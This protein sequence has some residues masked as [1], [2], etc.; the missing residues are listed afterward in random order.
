LA[1]FPDGEN[2]TPGGFVNLQN[3]EADY[4][5]QGLRSGALPAVGS[6][7]PDPTTRNINRHPDPTEDYFFHF[8][9]DCNAISGN[10]EWRN[11]GNNGTNQPGDQTWK[12]YYFNAS[13]NKVMVDQRG[14]NFIS[15]NNNTPLSEK[16]DPNISYIWEWD[17]VYRSHGVSVKLPFSEVTSQF[18]QCLDWNLT[19]SSSVNVN[20]GPKSS[21]VNV[22]SKKTPA[23][24]NAADTAKFY[25]NVHN[26]GPDD[27]TYDWYI[28]G[29]YNGNSFDITRCGNNTTNEPTITN[30][31]GVGAGQSCPTQVGRLEYW[32]NENTKAGGTTIDEGESYQFPS[33]ANPGDTYCERIV[34]TDA[35]GPKTASAPSAKACAVY[36]QIALSVD[37]CHSLTVT[38][39]SNLPY[40][41]TFIGSDG[42]IKYTNDLTGSRTWNNTFEDF[43]D[44]SLGGNTPLTILTPNSS[45]DSAVLWPQW[46]YRV[47]LDGPTGTLTVYDSD[48]I[49]HNG[50]PCMSVSCSVGL[51]T[52]P[53]SVE[54][55]EQTTVT[56]G[57]TINNYSGGTYG[58]PYD[59]NLAGSGGI[60]FNGTPAP[61]P[62]I[63]VTATKDGAGNP[64]PENV[65]KSV[66][67][68][69]NYT[70]TLTAR[71]TWYNGGDLSG[72]V[73]GPCS[74]NIT[75]STRATM[76]VTSGDIATGGGFGNSSGDCSATALFSNGK[77]RYTSPSTTT[78]KNAGGLRTF[79]VPNATKGS[80]GD[81]AAYAL[82]Y[83]D[84]SPSGPNGFYTAAAATSN[85]AYN[86]LMFA[87]TEPG[88]LGGLLG[89]DFTDAHCAP[90]YF[91]STI[92]MPHSSMPDPPGGTK[93]N[94]TSLNTKQY[95]HNGDLELKGG[96]INAGVRP[97]LYVD[98]NVTITGDITY[99]PWQFDTTNYNN[100]APYF[101]LI[102]RG[103]IYV[104]SSVGEINGLYIAQPIAPD[105]TDGSFVSCSNGSAFPNSGFIGSNCQSQ[106]NVK[107]S[108]IA[109]H[110]YA[111]RAKDTLSQ[112]ANTG[113]ASEIF[114]YL[115]SIVV[116]QPNFSPSTG[117][118]GVPSSLE[119]LTNLPPVF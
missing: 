69:L 7:A 65:T 12:L 100:N 71:L 59:V 115:P 26:S 64:V 25:H 35:K 97:T 45:G 11:A 101:T 62:P 107:G 14:D 118:A 20:G 27:A 46:M 91:D 80:G 55:D 13:G 81:F 43:R 18:R 44:P 61:P 89:G 88:N 76:R 102:V 84:G 70:G 34:Y 21:T 10:L 36:K 66:L 78:D 108:V 54:P 23:G 40:H 24:G 56:Y 82:G 119:N 16:L 5:F 106:L 38:D 41:L 32:T 117:G 116:G 68:T 87:N 74:Q 39:P 6:C 51:N 94:V 37:A 58:D 114:D 67:A 19:G 95:Y 85:N 83:I 22:L 109:Q 47:D 31:N 3:P 63:N 98:G 29:S 73:G 90:D 60:A 1:A 30:D 111:L 93:T 92:T 112:Y 57:V 79:A 28:E 2:F 15:A 105:G 75:P 4:C 9:P 8:S 42:S 49:N 17:N 99:S 96:N 50:G 104:D 110:V 48:N 113:S 77:N 72:V 33:N 103:N 53:A 86:A 52:N